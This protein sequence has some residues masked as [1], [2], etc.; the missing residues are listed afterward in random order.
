VVSIAELVL[1]H[2]SPA[3][4]NFLALETSTAVL[5]LELLLARLPQLPVL[6]K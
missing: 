6:V 3:T 2:I 5:L 4:L 1:L